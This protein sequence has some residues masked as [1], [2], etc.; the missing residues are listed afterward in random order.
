VTGREIDL[1]G[2]VIEGVIDDETCEMAGA[3]WCPGGPAPLVEDPY[4]AD[5]NNTHRL[6]RLHDRCA[7]ERAQDI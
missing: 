5:V 3:S 4:E 2:E 1:Y 7:Y 6:T